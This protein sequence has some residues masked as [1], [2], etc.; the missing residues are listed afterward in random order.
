MKKILL[1]FVLL[2][3]F[4]FGQTK[5]DYDIVNERYDRDIE[6]YKS[7]I[8]Y[9]ENIE[10]HISAIN[11]FYLAYDKIYN[12][13]N[14]PSKNA[15]QALIKNYAEKYYD[16]LKFEYEGKQISMINIGFTDKKS[17]NDYMLNTYHLI[18]MQTSNLI[19]K[20]IDDKGKQLDKQ[21]NDVLK[22]NNI[23]REEFNKMSEKD[24]STLLKEL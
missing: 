24:Q 11:E 6:D 2:S 8:R 7:I 12:L 20:K 10:R 23:K 22:K 4:V 3:G 18:K 19:E 1:L 5:S 17:L 9:D 21:L 16:I 14:L 13:D 15:Q